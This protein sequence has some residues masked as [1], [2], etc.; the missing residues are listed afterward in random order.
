MDLLTT[1]S[2]SMMEGFLPAGWDLK[3][4]DQL[5][6]I[7]GADLVRRQRWWH[8]EFEPVSCA[9]YADFDT[10]MGHEIARE[11]QKTG[12]A[13]QP[14]AIILPVGPM[15]M[16]RWTV[17]FLKEWGVRCDHVHGF[18]MDEWSDAQGNTLPSDN[19]GAFQYAMEH[20]LYGPLGTQTMPPRQRH[21]AVKT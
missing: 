20:A 11:I 8:P 5:A 15:G 19:P 14:L 6:S 4:I 3:K 1:I 9:N 10:F 21:F 18:N 2:G 17:Y 13:G 12:Q 7:S 16:Y